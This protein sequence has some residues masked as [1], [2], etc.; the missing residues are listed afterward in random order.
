MLTIF[1]RGR[2]EENCDAIA[3]HSKNLHGPLKVRFAEG[4][5]TL[6]KN[7]LQYEP[8]RSTLTF[9][10]K[11]WSEFLVKRGVVQA[12]EMN[13]VKKLPVER[14]QRLR[15]DIAAMRAFL[16]CVN[17]RIV[18]L[19]DLIV[20]EILVIQVA[21][22]E[23]GS[24]SA[25]IGMIWINP[26]ETWS[27][28]Y[29]AEIVFHELLHNILFLEDMTRGLMPDMELLESDHTRAFSAVRKT[30]R[31]F[32]SAFHAAFVTVGMMWFYHVSSKLV[33]GGQ[34]ARIAE[35]ITLGRK[36]VSDLKR[37]A[38]QQEAAGRPILT[39]NGNELLSAMA[40]FFETPDFESINSLLEV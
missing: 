38:A 25:A 8:K 4:L 16:A 23:A 18:E 2:I 17:P 31:F 10:R 32:D 1:E 33:R 9:C 14:M 6:M 20:A 5:Q 15:N 39:A 12:A 28:K 24:H 40:S 37:I 30:G 3:K 21:K 19:L 29:L 11:E 27:T 7:P 36:A 13:A 22:P 34:T 35:C 26:D